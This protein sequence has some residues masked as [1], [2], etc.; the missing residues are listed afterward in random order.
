MRNRD[1][2]QLQPSIY[3]QLHDLAERWFVRQPADHTL[4]PTALVHEAYLRLAAA[5]N[6]PSWQ[7]RSH[8]MAVAASAMRQILIDH[9]RRRS[10]VKRG[11]SWR[12]VTLTDAVDNG[13]ETV[14]DLLD[15]EAALEKLSVLNERQCR[16]VEMRFLAG[17]TV[18]ET[19]EALGI[20]P[21]TVRLDWRM[22]RAW[23]MRALE[24]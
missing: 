19:A 22:A 15:L 9:A 16:I 4:Q 6:G 12:R 14:V 7:N 24:E 13:Q 11:R 23:L 5:S 17:M 18:D 3:G 21:R 8:F 20:A 2:S 10:A 1:Y